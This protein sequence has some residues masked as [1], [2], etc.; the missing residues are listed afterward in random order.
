M[1][2]PVSQICLYQ[3]LLDGRAKVTCPLSSF[4]DADS[5]KSLSC[6]GLIGHSLGDGV[7]LKK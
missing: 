4:A 7:F 6:L 1:E 2:F 3:P 5:T